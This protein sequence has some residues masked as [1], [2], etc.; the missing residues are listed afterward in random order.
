M[1]GV[2]KLSRSPRSLTSGRPAVKSQCE[3]WLERFERRGSKFRE[4]GLVFPEPN[5]RRG[6]RALPTLQP[7][8]ERR[9]VCESACQRSD[10]L[11]TRRRRLRRRDAAAARSSASMRSPLAARSS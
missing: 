9:L 2:K 10:R 8:L 7:W 11:P 6:S 3:R 4:R 5:L 1:T